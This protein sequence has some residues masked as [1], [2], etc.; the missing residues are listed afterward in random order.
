MP[1]TLSKKN[2]STG[3]SCEYCKILKSMFFY[4]TPLVA[5]SEYMKNRINICSKQY[6]NTCSNPWTL[7]VLVSFNTELEQI[8]SFRL[9]YCLLSGVQVGIYLLKFNNGNTKTMCE[10]CSKLTIKSLTSLWC[11]YLSIF[12]RF[13]TLFCCFHC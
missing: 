1:T 3:A 8:L 5:A 9:G 11:L 13:Y 6:L 7:V 4:R 12:N 10:I 2:S